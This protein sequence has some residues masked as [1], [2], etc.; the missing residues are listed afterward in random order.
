MRKVVPL[1]FDTTPRFVEPTR[2]CDLNDTSL[3]NALLALRP[4]AHARGYNSRQLEFADTFLVC[5]DY[6]TMQAADLKKKH[7]GLR[8]Q[9]VPAVMLKTYFT[10]ALVFGVDVYVS[11]ALS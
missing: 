8:V 6:W 9:T 11:Y 2:P 1:A 10:W 4:L 3:H 7:K 5:S